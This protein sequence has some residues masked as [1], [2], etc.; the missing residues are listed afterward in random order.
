MPV[1]KDRPKSPHSLVSV[2]TRKSLLKLTPEETATPELATPE[3]ATPDATMLTTGGR[4]ESTHYKSRPRKQPQVRQVQYVR[5][6]LK[7]PLA[8][9]TDGDLVTENT[10]SAAPAAPA[11][12]D[13]FSSDRR[14]ISTTDPYQFKDQTPANRPRPPIS[15]RLSQRLAQA[16][17]RF[18]L[19]PTAEPLAVPN[20]IENT[21]TPIFNVPVEDLVRPQ[22]DSATNS[23]TGQA[24]DSVPDSIFPNTTTPSAPAANTPQEFVPLPQTPGDQPA[25]EGGFRFDEP[26]GASAPDNE[27]DIR[28]SV[29]R[30]LEKL[31]G[32]P[33]VPVDGQLPSP[34]SDGNPL[35][36]DD[37]DAEGDDE[38]KDTNTQPTPS[39]L[40]KTNGRDCNADVCAA[41][42]AK[43]K[44]RELTSMSLNI[45]PSIEPTEVDMARVE[46]TRIE[47]L[48]KAPVRT[49][50]S[51]SGNVI[52]DGYFD[53]YRN[54]K[55]YVRT[56]NGTIRAIPHHTL[57]DAD[58][59]FVSAWWELPEECN[60][61][62]EQFVM[63]D[64]RLMTYTWVASATCSKPL[65]F[66]QVGVEREGHSAGPI[67]QPLLSGVHFFGDIVM[68]PYHAGITPPNECV[69][70]LGHYRPGDCAPWLMPGFPFSQRAF[71]WEGLALGAAIALLP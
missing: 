59:C 31:E 38:G 34:G 55:V 27:E 18:D 68:M 48:S 39:E 58:R 5:P 23:P 32:L 64:H 66:E 12:G 67:V 8:N 43:L 49:W 61:E 47:K 3:L 35:S 65:Y 15:D 21:Q 1:L 44:R 37:E 69:Y 26:A 33:P 7:L 40:A 42:F 45:T 16:P 57:S 24:A 50:T 20:P 63:R 17:S 14:F 4:K 36:L 70:P 2:V 19:N 13:V 30:Q 60:F 41:D 29:Q 54:N 52:A 10:P 46:E 11:P 6:N 28:S 9:L 53:D 51:R 22:D 62:G 56:V 71:K 25:S